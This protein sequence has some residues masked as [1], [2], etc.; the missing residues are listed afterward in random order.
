MWEE[1]R[2]SGSQMTRLSLRTD[3]TSSSQGYARA[4][5]ETCFRWIW[6]GELLFGRMWARGCFCF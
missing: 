5:K 3:S 6:M 1:L 4:L 2:V